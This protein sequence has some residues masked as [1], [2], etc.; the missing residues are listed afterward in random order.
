MKSKFRILI[1]LCIVLAC[2]ISVAVLGALLKRA[3]AN[4]DAGVT[5]DDRLSVLI[6]GLDD[7]AENTDTLMIL[8][9]TPSTGRLELLQIPRDTY[10]R[11]DGTEGKINRLYHQYI[12]KFGLKNGA[13]KYLNTVSALFSLPLDA[14]LLFDTK[15]LSAFVDSLGG[16]E[17]NVPY[18]ITYFDEHTQKEAVIQNGRQLLDG[19]AAVAFVRHR[20]SYT[21]GDLG[22]LD[23]QMRFVA[24]AFKKLASLRFPM[25][26]VEIYQKNAAKVL[27]NLS[28]K[29]IIKFMM[30]Y[31]EKR[32]EPSVRVMRLPG[33]AM[34][35]AHSVWYYVLNKAA[36]SDMLEKYFDVKEDS[37]DPEAGFVREGE[38]IFDNIY[39]APPLAYRVYGLAEAEGADVLRK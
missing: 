12:E 4:T 18:A 20:S 31:L 27:T 29:D 38:E 35:D 10:V 17:V 8:S 25:Q 24:S 39:H 5:S 22:R 36:V 30:V 28:E 9:A 6:A 32:E 2:S 26:Y 15:A 34:Q 19:N 21:E 1:T 11:V 33:E 37:F 7:A 3:Y 13:E 23:A 16:I 14:Y